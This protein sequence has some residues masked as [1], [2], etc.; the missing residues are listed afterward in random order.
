M[1][2]GTNQY[3]KGKYRSDGAGGWDPNYKDTQLGVVPM[4]RHIDQH[5]KELA[6]KAAAAKKLAE[7]TAPAEH[8][9]D[10][11][12]PPNLHFTQ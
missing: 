6:A 12:A 11:A 4:M 1:F 2:A 5:E 8:H 9:D 7:G 3:E 10:K